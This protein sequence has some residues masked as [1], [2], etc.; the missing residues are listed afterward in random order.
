MDLQGILE[1]PACYASV[2]LAMLVSEPFS[3]RKMHDV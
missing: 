3:L 1:G 2:E